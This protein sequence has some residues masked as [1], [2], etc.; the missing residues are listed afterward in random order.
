MSNL[1]LELNIYKYTNQELLNLLSLENNYNRDILSFKIITMKNNIFSLDLSSKEKN[2][3]IMF[4][5]MVELS[6]IKELEIKNLK[7]EQV[8]MKKK[9]LYLEKKLKK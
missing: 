6:L 3:I 2:D 4:L 9:I 1:N 7:K 5:S 8:E